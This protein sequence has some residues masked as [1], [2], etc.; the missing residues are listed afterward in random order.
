MITL[1][2]ISISKPL[3]SDYTSSI[4]VGVLDR[5]YLMSQQV[6]KIIQSA[7][8]LRLINVIRPKV[9]KSVA[10][11]VVMCYLCYIRQLMV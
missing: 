8:K 4:R 9:T 2:Y 11:R 7:Y 10:E 1:H 5:H 6:L 3:V